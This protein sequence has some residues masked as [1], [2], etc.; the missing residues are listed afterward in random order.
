MRL[1]P[2]GQGAAVLAR[3]QK[4]AVCQEEVGQLLPNGVL[5]LAEPHSR[6]PLL[7]VGTGAEQP[8]DLL[9]VLLDAVGGVF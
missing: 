5:L 9:A 7:G 2:V 1:D 4:P 6:Q 3:H 8:V